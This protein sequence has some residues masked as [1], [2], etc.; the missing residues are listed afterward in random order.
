MK[1]VSTYIFKNMKL[2]SAG[3]IFIPVQT[4]TMVSISVKNYV[5]LRKSY[6][7]EAPK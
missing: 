4:K 1:V 5:G 3:E 2:F 6:S 7:F